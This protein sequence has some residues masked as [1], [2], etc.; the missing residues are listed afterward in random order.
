VQT[1]NAA[2]VDPGKIDR[3]ATGIPVVP[4]FDGYRIAAILGIVLFH[5]L[6]KSGV[7]VNAGGSAGGQLIW[8]ALPQLV[9]VL[10]IVSGFVV[11]L[12]TVA[13]GGEFGGV[14]AYAIRRAARILPA[15]WVSLI[16]ALLV[17]R[18]APDAVTTQLPVPNPGLGS[19]G[20]H[21]LDLQTPATMFD[22]ELRLGFGINGSVWTLSLEIG[23]YVVLALIA[24]TYFRHPFAGL[25]VAAGIAIA[26]RQLFSHIGTVV[27]AFGAHP[28][29][30][31]LTFD[32]IASA[33][34][35]P[36]WAFSFACG[37]TGAWLFVWLRDRYDPGLLA[38]RALQV[39]AVSVP[40]FV[41]F[42]YLFGRYAITT[43]F[44]Y[45]D[46]VARLH[47]PISLGYTGALATSMVALTFAP[48]RLQRP[49]THP[50]VRWL[51]DISYGIFLYHLI[52][53]YL[54]GQMFTLST[55]G[56]L[57]AFAAWCGLV[58]P[59]TVLAGYA[60]ARYLEQPIRRWAHR[61]GRRVQARGLGP[62]APSSAGS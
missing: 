26:W 42:A 57:G 20:L 25:L 2:I 51:A 43:P 36:S 22:H 46:A 19:V 59:V 44:P 60:S 15:F 52:V 40:A 9:D 37:M 17:I 58:I 29:P 47:S 38:R 7:V 21:F 50:A 8:G 62:P 12:P 24:R 1:P 56:S 61:Y 11:F 3:A 32:V 6:I 54:A 55:D 27:H 13:R 34:Q 45:A 14:G 28:T 41:L 48:A 23:F 49:F 39:L 35:L 18:L 10:F 53:A 31:S 30:Q 33:S 16:V 5:V 4:A